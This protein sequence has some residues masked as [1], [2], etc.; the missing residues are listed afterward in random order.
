MLHTRKKVRTYSCYSIFFLPQ[1]S[2]FG[3]FPEPGYQSEVNE[4]RKKKMQWKNVYKLF[5]IAVKS[6]FS[7]ST[8]EIPFFSCRLKS[9]PES[10]TILES[11]EAQVQV[12]KALNSA[13]MRKRKE[14]EKRLMQRLSVDDDDDDDPEML[15]SPIF[16]LVPRGQCGEITWFISRAI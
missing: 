11:K 13:L 1:S 12:M 3:R 10:R 15:D 7:P 8:I 16:H 9:V 4:K 14:N 2:T 6:H 5:L